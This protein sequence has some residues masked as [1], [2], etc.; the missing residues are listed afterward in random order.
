LTPNQV[1]FWPFH[2]PLFFC[3]AA[4]S[5]GS[6][7]HTSVEDDALVAFVR[8]LVQKNRGA[9]RDVQPAGEIRRGGKR[10]RGPGTS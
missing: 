5:S 1:Q 3:A 8:Y 10:V 2:F 6:V 9:T 4:G 7:V